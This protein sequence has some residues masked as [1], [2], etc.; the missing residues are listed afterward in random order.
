MLLFLLR[1]FHFSIDI[2]Y[3]NIIGIVIA[4][5]VARCGCLSF[6]LFSHLNILFDSNLGAD[7]DTNIKSQFGF[8]IN[9]L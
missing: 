2:Q 7:V 4:V 6:Y 5:A 1:V 9:L 8:S 3:T